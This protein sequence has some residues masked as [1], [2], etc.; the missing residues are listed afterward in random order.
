MSKGVKQYPRIRD[1]V[2]NEE[3]PDCRKRKPGYKS[4]CAIYNAV[5]MR[6]EPNAIANLDKFFTRKGCKYFDMKGSV[7]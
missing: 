7:K 1:Y 5:F 3:C 6:M 2:E 4:D